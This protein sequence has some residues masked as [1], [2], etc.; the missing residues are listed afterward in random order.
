V[1]ARA[2]APKI[3]VPEDGADRPALRQ[4]GAIAAGCFAV[5]LAWPWVAGVKLVP[6]PPREAEE[7]A[8]ASA[9]PAVAPA[10]GSP[11]PALAATAAAPSVTREQGLRI[12]ELKIASCR[13]G[14]RKTERCDRPL[15][16]TLLE[17]PVKGLAA[18][19]AA[20]GASGRFSLGLELDLAAGK[21]TDVFAGKSTSL[22]KE[23]AR[24]LLA[25]ADEPFRKLALSGVDHE[26]A[27]YTVFQLVEFVPPG[28]PVAPPAPEEQTTE[29][30]GIATV[31]WD[32]AVVRD[33]PDGGKIVARL[34]YGTRVAVSARRG[35]WYEV[36]YDSRG[37]KGWVH[38]NALGL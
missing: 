11:V 34:R 17:A 26:H 28:T 30:S 6:S 21:V 35:K 19:E 14:K 22:P 25:C 23:V 9:V 32:S 24:A 8:V 18:C 37:N 38:R 13:D 36:R 31:G 3:V 15:L 5:G 29:A 20:Q 7:P 4:V 12:E 1:A 27:R 16:A 10:P 33:E 2:E